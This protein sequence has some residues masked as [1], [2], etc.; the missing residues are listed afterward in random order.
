[1]AL[2]KEFD[3]EI[4]D[5]FIHPDCLAELVEMKQNG[6]ISQ[7]SLKAILREMFV[8]GI[9]PYILAF[10]MDLYNAKQ[11][12]K[13]NSA[14][15]KVMESNKNIVDEIAGGK[16]KALGRLIGLV[17]K[18]FGGKADAKEIRDLFVSKINERRSA[19]P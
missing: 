5:C 16:D 19:K 3:V 1:M 15:D 8:T 7:T 6:L 13:I 11:D 17:M 12:G 9:S 18:E 2:S 4:K 14:I 10:K